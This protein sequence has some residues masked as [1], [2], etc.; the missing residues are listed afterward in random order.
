MSRSLFKALAYSKVCGARKEN[1]KRSAR[2]RGGLNLG[3]KRR[4]RVKKARRRA[5]HAKPH[6]EIGGRGE[7]EDVVF[8]VK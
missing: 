5:P 2:K 3:E 4:K 6:W 7:S 1:R 8:G